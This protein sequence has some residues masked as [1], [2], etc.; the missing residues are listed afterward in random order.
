MYQ[1]YHKCIINVSKFIIL[2]YVRA[3]TIKLLEENI[4]VNLCDLGLDNGFYTNAHRNQICQT[5]KKEQKVKTA[6]RKKKTYSRQSNKDKNSIRLLV[7]SNVSKKK[8]E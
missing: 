6:R 1:I 2:L 5:R 8:V 3:K 4:G 7:V